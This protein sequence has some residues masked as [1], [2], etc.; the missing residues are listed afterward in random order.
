MCNY[1]IWFHN[2]ASGYVVECVQC[3]KLQVAFGNIAI[4]LSVKEY[5]NF[6][7]YLSQVVTNR[8]YA[9][10]AK[11]KS[12][13]IHTPA[14]C[15][16]FLLSEDELHGLQQMFEYTDNEMKAESLIKLFNEDVH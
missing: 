13:M 12:I 8:E 7:Q 6:R 4:T 10:N 5:E 16:H 1:K 9:G 14:Q 11:V 2:A 15:I 3:N